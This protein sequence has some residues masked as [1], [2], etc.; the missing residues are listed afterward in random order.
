MRL[1]DFNDNLY[2]TDNIALI[3]VYIANNTFMRM[4]DSA[5]DTMRKVKR[6]KM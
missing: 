6:G 3:N 4:V 1:L 2:Y 5:H